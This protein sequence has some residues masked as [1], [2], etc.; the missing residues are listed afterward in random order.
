[1]VLLEKLKDIL[2]PP[3][4]GLKWK[5]ECLVALMKEQ[6]KGIQ[7]KMAEVKIYTAMLKKLRRAKRVQSHS[8]FIVC[9]M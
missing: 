4:M 5:R 8:V 2:N 9:K 1:L 7:D 6:D 3:L